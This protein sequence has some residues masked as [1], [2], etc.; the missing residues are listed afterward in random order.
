MWT[1]LTGEMTPL[2]NMNDP[3]DNVLRAAGQTVQRSLTQSYM[4]AAEP[5]WGVSSRGGQNHAR[6]ADEH[7][8][9]LKEEGIIPLAWPPD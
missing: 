3:A 9:V 7:I 1:D 6:T 8:L 4:R 2:F 5:D